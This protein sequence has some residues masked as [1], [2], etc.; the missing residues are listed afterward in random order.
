MQVRVASAV[1]LAH[2]ARTKWGDDFVRADAKTRAEDGLRQ[3]V[4]D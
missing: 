1:H 3:R 2:G 4:V